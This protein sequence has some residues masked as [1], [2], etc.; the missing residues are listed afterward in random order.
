M[1]RCRCLQAF[2]DGGLDIRLLLVAHP[3]FSLTSPWASAMLCRDGHGIV[4]LTT[5]WS[6]WGPQPLRPPE[7]RCSQ[8]RTD[9]V[10]VLLFLTAIAVVPRDGTAPPVEDLEPVTV[11]VVDGKRCPRDRVHVPGPVSTRRAQSPTH[12]D[13]WT[14]AASPAGTFE[15]PAPPAFRLS[16]MAKPPDYI[17][18]YPLLK[19][20]MIKSTDRPRRVVVRLRRGITVR[21]TVRDSRTREPI[22]GATVAPVIHVLPIWVPDE[23]KQVKTGADGRYEVRGVDPALG[24]SASHPDYIHDLEFPNGKTTGPDHDV[25]LERGVS[26]AATV[27]DADGQ[28]L[29]GVTAEDLNSR[30][31]TSDAGGRL[32]L[33][34]PN[35][36]LGLT[37]RKDGFIARKLE[38]EEISRELPKPKGLVVVMER[39][40]ELTGRVVVPDGGPVPAFAVAAG[41][42]PSSVGERLAR[43]PGPRRPLPPEPLE[44]GHDL[45]GRLRRRVRGVGGVG[46]RETRRP[47]DGGPPGARSCR[48]GEGR[49]ARGDPESGQGDAAPAP[50]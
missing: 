4:S 11:A 31:A 18:G 21:G 23:D 14:P 42:A 29:E 27:V 44:D 8:W 37:F 7:V 50:R 32:V 40:I 47:G 3:A 10:T 24:V 2:G 20:F 49:G 35:L 17:G 43:G 38:P 5:V 36:V 16:V 48:V 6:W 1:T 45:G 19:E 39:T 28:R 34:N 25:F 41:P 12:R 26:I 46:G 22:A 9:Q 30:Q 15:V 33:R 13:V